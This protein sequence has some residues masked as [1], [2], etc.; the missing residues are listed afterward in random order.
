[1]SNYGGGKLSWKSL[2]MSFKNHKGYLHQED[3]IMQLFIVYTNKVPENCSN[4][5]L[6]EPVSINILESKINLF[7]LIK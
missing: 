2:K 4:P 1:M 7:L 6:L 3:M 5:S